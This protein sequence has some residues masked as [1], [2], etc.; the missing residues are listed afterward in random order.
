M[1][2]DL[3]ILKQFSQEELE[4]ILTPMLEKFSV[5]KDIS[6]IDKCE[7]DLTKYTEKIAKELCLFGGN[8]VMNFLRGEGVS[9]KELVYDVCKDMKVDVDSN[10]SLEKME[11]ELL[12]KTLEKS[13]DEMEAEEKKKLLEELKKKG[14]DFSKT[15]LSAATLISR[16]CAGGVV[17][18]MLSVKIANT[19]SKSLLN[20]NLPIAANAGLTTISL[21]ATNPIYL[22]I[23][24]LW[25][26]AAPA[27]KVT[28]PCVIFIAAMRRAKTLQK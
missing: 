6:K 5:D 1:D 26:V 16:F 3:E 18:Y 10:D 19:V 8:T 2:K 22:V 12:T 11:E 4:V 14:A 9:Y 20:R 25:T 13:W 27:K 17:S 24:G 28:I 15:S 21:T 23:A 7:Q